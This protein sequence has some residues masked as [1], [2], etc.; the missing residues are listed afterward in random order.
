VT[1]NIP[2]VTYNGGEEI[3]TFKDKNVENNFNNI[4][5]KNNPTEEAESMVEVGNYDVEKED[6][7]E[8]VKISKKL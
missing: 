1:P 8:I 2:E 7:L 6:D 5:L 3:A 4:T